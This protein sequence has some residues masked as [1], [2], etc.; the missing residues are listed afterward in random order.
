MGGKPR[1]GK[2]GH[3]GYALALTL[4]PLVWGIGYTQIE[5]GPYMGGKPWAGKL[6][7]SG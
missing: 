4:S 3:S 6:C 2:V 5:G 7:H 1:A